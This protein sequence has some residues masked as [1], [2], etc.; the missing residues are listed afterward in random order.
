MTPGEIKLHQRS[1]VLELLYEDGTTFQLPAEYLRVY[2]PSADV[3]GHSP[4]QAVLQHGKK[5]VRIVAIEPQGHYAI[6]IKFSDG[7][8]AGIFSWPY[9]YDLG[10]HQA[11]LW[12]IYLERLERDGKK[13]EPHYIAKG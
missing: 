12:E 5:G 3:Q 8:D 4:D 6:R 11:Q 1:G 9:L 13:R 10:A 7:H 2:A